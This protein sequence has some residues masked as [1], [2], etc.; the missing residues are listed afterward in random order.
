MNAQP[1]TPDLAA[2]KQR[3]QKAWSAGDYSKI[4][5]IFVV[6][7]EMLCEAVD[8]RSGRRVLDVATGHGNTA[9]AAARRFCEV[10]GIDYVPAML[11]DANKRAAA[12]GLQ[13]DFREGAAEEIPFPDASFDYVLSTNGAMFAPDQ[14]KTASELLRV[15]KPGGK[16]GMANFT[17]DSFAGQV[18]KLT[19]KY[20]PPP[21]SGLKPPFV[22]GT[23]ERLR[24]LLGEGVSSL[25]VQRRSFVFRY[26]SPQFYVELS[27]MH[28]GVI[29]EAL[30]ALDTSKQGALLGELEDLVHRYNH[31]G[32]ETMVAPSDYLEVVAVRR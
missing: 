3:Q 17:P 2:I 29:R 31:S 30:E 26:P 28:V 16:I 21:P 23:E 8:M 10:S 14:E 32:D 24:E 7:A 1:P 5:V 9:L 6:I 12:E 20:L 18:G 15:C 13:V 25:E 22:W 27:Q 11:E 19:A 4:G